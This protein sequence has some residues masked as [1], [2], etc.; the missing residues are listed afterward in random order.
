MNGKKT[1]AKGGAYWGQILFEV[2]VYLLCYDEF[3]TYLTLQLKKVQDRSIETMPKIKPTFDND[4]LF[5]LF[6]RCFDLQN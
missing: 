3:T 6:E 4:S 2:A 5:H 1:Q